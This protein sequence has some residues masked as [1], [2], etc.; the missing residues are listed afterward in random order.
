MSGWRRTYGILSH[1]HILIPHR[2]AQMLILQVVEII[3][4]GQQSGN[5]RTLCSRSQ[6]NTPHQH[7]RSVINTKQNTK[8]R[9][10]LRTGKGTPGVGIFVQL[11]FSV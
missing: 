8:E 1:A 6:T 2:H 10:R 5:L 3:D 4:E 7:S 9:E 11:G